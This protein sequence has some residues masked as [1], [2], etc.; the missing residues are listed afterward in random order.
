M[1]QHTKG[2]IAICM[3]IELGMLA[4]CGEASA[5]LPTPKESAAAPVASPTPAGK[6]APPLQPAP[7]KARISLQKKTDHFDIYCT[8]SEATYMDTLPDQVEESYQ[9]ITSD[10]DVKMKNRISLYIYPDIQS[11]HIA[12]GKPDAPAWYIG[13]GNYCSISVV[14]PGL[15]QL[16]V[17]RHEMTHSICGQFAGLP[18]WLFQGIAMFEGKETPASQIESKV[19]ECVKAGKI[20]SFRDLSVDYDSYSQMN[21]SY[22]FS[23]T[24]VDYLINRFGFEKLKVLLR[25]PSDFP[26]VFGFSEDEVY[27]DF[28]AYLIQKYKG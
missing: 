4:G 12:I 13:E 1:L 27:K 28:K 21:G 9:K 2:I 7:T 15:S 3:L 14:S 24:M 8:P 19:E 11:F 18:Q 17:I 16:R 20:P 5:P 25:A 22:E 23:Y 10:L 26:G 6:R